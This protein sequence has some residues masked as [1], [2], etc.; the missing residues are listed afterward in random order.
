MSGFFRNDG[1]W[2][3]REHGAPQGSQQQALA[4]VHQ[5][6]DRVRHE[7]SK[8]SD[9]LRQLLRQHPVL[10]QELKDKDGKHPLSPLMTYYADEV[11]G[12]ERQESRWNNRLT[13]QR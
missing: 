2:V 8:P 5:A 7:E 6:L 9:E 13:L 4:A 11:I 10:R 12:V 1:T 3:Q